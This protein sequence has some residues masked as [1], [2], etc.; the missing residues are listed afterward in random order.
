M[1]T[2]LL[3]TTVQVRRVARLGHSRRVYVQVRQ[4]R[5]VM[6]WLSHGSPQVDPGVPRLPVPAHVWLLLPPSVP[7]DV[8]PALY[9]L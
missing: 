3:H 9:P 6:R 2:S 7:Y 4:A 8:L 1:L 5:M